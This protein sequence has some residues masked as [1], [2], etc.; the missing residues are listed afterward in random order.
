MIIARGLPNFEGK[1]A[2]LLVSGNHFTKFFLAEGGQVHELEDLMV[3]YPK[4]S[5]HEGF[6]QQ[7][8]MGRVFGMGS[9]YEP[10]EGDVIKK[11]IIE[12]RKHL[13]K[14]IATYSPDEYYIFA[15]K[16]LHR[17]LESDL[18]IKEKRKIIYEFYGNYTKKTPFE[19]LGMIKTKRDS[20]YGTKVPLKDEALKILNIPKH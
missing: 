2:I 11:L 19:L 5:D 4:Y 3:P 20:I 13:A 17:M 7:S 10:K 9:V 14:I 18:P 16:Y 15:P 12:I 8:G 1:A 6:F